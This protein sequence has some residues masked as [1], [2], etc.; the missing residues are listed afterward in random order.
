MTHRYHPIL[1][2]VYSYAYNCEQKISPAAQNEQT[3]AK[4][5]AIDNLFVPQTMP[6]DLLN[7]KQWS[8]PQRKIGVSLP[9]ASF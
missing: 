4:S 1:S 7:N 6:D 8:Y 9:N 2:Q 5:S 3:V